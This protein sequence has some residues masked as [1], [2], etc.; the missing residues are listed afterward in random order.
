L[1]DK[2]TESD[3]KHYLHLQAL[4]HHIEEQL[5]EAG[6]ELDYLEQARKEI[7]RRTKEIGEHYD[8]LEIQFHRYNKAMLELA[9]KLGSKETETD[10][11]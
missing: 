8:Q 10:K 2:I 6:K 4:H 7:E 11:S 1:A 9:K 3:V 5:A